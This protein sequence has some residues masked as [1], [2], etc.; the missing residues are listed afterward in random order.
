MEPQY[1]TSDF[2]S[3]CRY[4]VPRMIT[5]TLIEIACRP[6]IDKQLSSS[7]DCNATVVAR[8]VQIL[9]SMLFGLLQLRTKSKGF[10]VCDCSISANQQPQG[11]DNCFAED[12]A[13]VRDVVL[14]SDE[15][16]D[17]VRHALFFPVVCLWFSSGNIFL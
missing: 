13:N 14:L 3:A 5:Y 12:I 4:D 8:H 17:A 16:P 11:F 10:L 7:V 6:D 15:D 2:A 9:L 1:L